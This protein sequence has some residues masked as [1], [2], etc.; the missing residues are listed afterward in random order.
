VAAQ[1]ESGIIF[2][3]T[4]TLKEAITIEAGRVK[5]SNFTDYP[6]LRFD[7]RPAIEVYIV[8]STELPTGAGEMGNPPLAP[9][10][11]NAIFAATG[12]RIRRI[13]IHAEDLKQP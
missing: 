1:M 8:P 13:P 10:V 4:A 11:A 3:L 9:A 12:K 7:E 2:G 5:Q 6:V